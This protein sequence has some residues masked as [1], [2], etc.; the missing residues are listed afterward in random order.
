M[1]KLIKTFICVFS[2]AVASLGLV[3]CDEVPPAE[4]VTLTLDMVSLEY[5]T[6]AYD[7]VAKEPV[8]TITVNEEAVDAEE[9]TIAY[10]NN[11]VVGTASV[12][13]TAVEGS[14][15]VSG[16]VTANFTIA[17]GTAVA[18]TY[19]ELVAA[20]A[21]TNYNT[22]RVTD[23]I[24]VPVGETLSVPADTTVVLEEVTIQ[25]RGVINNQGTIMALAKTRG[26]LIADFEVANYIKLTANIEAVGRWDDIDVNAET[27]DYKFTLDMNGYNIESELN[28]RTRGYYE[29]EYKYFN[30][31]IDVSIINTSTQVKS[32]IGR[33]GDTD[34]CYYGIMANG[35]ED[36]KI[37]LDNVIV[38]GYYGGAYTNGTCNIGGTFTATN[39]Q[40]RAAVSSGYVGV[41][42]A[43]NYNY[44]FTNCAFS[45]N[46]AYYAKSG[47]HQ[48]TNC[49][50]GASRE[51][52]DPIYHGSAANPTGSAI[53]VDS[54]LGSYG[55]SLV[56]NITG[57]E[58]TSRYGYGIEEVST[59]PNGSTPINYS[60][61]T[62]TGVEFDECPLGDVY[63]N[64]V[65]K[66]D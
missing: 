52:R 26:Q 19:E 56:V 66:N 44:T 18:T 58:I 46:S 21:N 32:V 39:C 61:V 1:R 42:L 15:V 31:S 37:S 64:P 51:Y 27:R 54:C 34:D 9:Y 43:A 49:T 40:F 38:Q 47:N 59:A 53:V 62:Y 41:Y 33:T 45:G 22:V 13:V 10:S 20:L 5:A 48:L 25:N 65:A 8:V 57:G 60:T 55:R 30:H 12:V 29:E 23:Y 4:P 14:E 35:K 63:E 28:F 7:G 16:T 11:T 17:K 24:I 2:L 36:L 6:V 3:A 50:F